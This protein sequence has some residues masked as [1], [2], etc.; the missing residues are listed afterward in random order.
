MTISDWLLSPCLLAGDRHPR[1]LIPIKA[2]NEPDETCC[3]AAASE[4]GEWLWSSNCVRTDAQWSSVHSAKTERHAVFTR[5]AQ[6]PAW[7]RACCKVA[8]SDG[9]C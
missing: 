9:L 3:L 6:A 4:P 1:S 2:R 7:R 8:L 5:F